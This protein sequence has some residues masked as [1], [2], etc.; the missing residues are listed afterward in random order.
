MS[1]RPSRAILILAVLTCVGTFAHADEAIPAPLVPCR[2]V[3]SMPHDPDAFT[4]GLIWSDGLFLESVGGFGTSD[5]RVVAPDTG[6]PLRSSALD[7][8]LFGEGLALV[9]TQAGRR[10]VQ[11]TWRAGQARFLDP[12]SLEP[13]GVAAYQ[14][15]GWGLTTNGRGELLMSDGSSWLTRRDPDDFSILDRMEVTDHGAPVS[16]LNELEWVRD[17]D[18]AGPVILANILGRDRVA[19][20]APD[21]GQVR[22]WIDCSGLHPTTQR[23]SP[24]NVLNGI[25][26]DADGR[27]LFVT[28][29]RWPRM[30]E[31]TMDPPR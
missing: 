26:W 3:R 17:L 4:Q 11:L 19:A 20:I 18:P 23:R 29:K 25:A 15:E 6:A 9:E 14:G 10:L 8:A 13:L 16:M 31:I 1:A 7:A 30:F 2:V 27:R 12:E 21:T 28:G 5:I 24:H 22:Y